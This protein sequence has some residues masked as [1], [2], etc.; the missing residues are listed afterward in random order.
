MLKAHISR[1]FC[2]IQ[3]AKTCGDGWLVE[4]KKTVLRM[5]SAKTKECQR[6]PQNLIM[7]EGKG[8]KDE[9]HF[10]GD[11]SSCGFSAWV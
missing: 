7:N 9:I 4:R 8:V 6:E 5:M 1:T 3:V 11:S 10:S 2:V